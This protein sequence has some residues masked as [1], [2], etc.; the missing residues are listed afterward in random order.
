MTTW[1]IRRHCTSLDHTTTSMCFLE[2][3]TSSGHL[4]PFHWLTW[5]LLETLNSLN[6]Q[7]P[8]PLISNYSWRFF[9]SCNCPRDDQNRWLDILEPLWYYSQRQLGT[10][11]PSSITFGMSKESSCL[12]WDVLYHPMQAV[13]TLFL[14]KQPIHFTYWYETAFTA[15][16]ILHHG[17]FLLPVPLQDSGIPEPNL[18]PDVVLL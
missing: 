8:T 18:T 15:N 2:P 4:A 5:D 13:R 7:T 14:F 12:P 3:V 10:Q 17:R 11:L 16:S 6:Y 9:L 1:P